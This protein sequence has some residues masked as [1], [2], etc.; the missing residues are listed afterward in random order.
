MVI[1]VTVNLNHTGGHS[2]MPFASPTVIFFT[3]LQAQCMDVWCEGFCC[4]DINFKTVFQSAS[5]HA[6]FIQKL[7][8]F[9]ARGHTCF[10]DPISKRKPPPAP[11]WHQPL[12]PFQN[13]KY[14]TAAPCSFPGSHTILPTKEIIPRHWPRR[15][16]PLAIWL[17]G[18]QFV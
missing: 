4:R 17:T 7:R 18:K 6:I 14:A 1:S 3:N 16:S 15:L 2:A 12:P 8:N 5:E 10:P 13:P 9:L 11:P